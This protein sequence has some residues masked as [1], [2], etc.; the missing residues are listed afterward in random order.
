[1]L[2]DWNGSGVIPDRN[3]LELYTPRNVF[4]PF[5]VIGS[6]KEG[7]HVL[8]PGK[9][10]LGGYYIHKGF[11]DCKIECNHLNKLIQAHLDDYLKE[12]K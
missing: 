1:M 12:N 8:L 7:Y 3:E 6:M 11:E 2:G 4:K 9:N 10:S 5:K